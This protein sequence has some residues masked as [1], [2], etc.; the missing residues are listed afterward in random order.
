MAEILL[1]LVEV[2]H[3]NLLGGRVWYKA[4]QTSC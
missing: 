3:E 2:F 4:H 1:N